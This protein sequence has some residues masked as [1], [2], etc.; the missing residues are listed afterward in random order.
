MKNIVRNKN[1][2]ASY[3]HERVWKQNKHNTV[4]QLKPIPL[5]VPSYVIPGSVGGNALL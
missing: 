2:R 1:W 5:P 4:S 3:D